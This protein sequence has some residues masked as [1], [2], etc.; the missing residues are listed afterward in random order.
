M[1]T[2]EQSIANLGEG[3]IKRHGKGLLIE[4]GGDSM[5][6]QQVRIY[7]Y[8]PGVLADFIRRQEE[9]LADWNEELLKAD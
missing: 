2:V 4:V 1:L 9:A 3:T 5:A 7:V 8:S 6:Q